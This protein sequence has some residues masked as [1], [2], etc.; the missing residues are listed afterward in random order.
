MDHPERAGSDRADRVDFDR[1][2]RLEFWGARPSVRCALQARNGRRTFPASTRSK[3]L[4]SRRRC[5]AQT[6]NQYTPTV[7]HLSKV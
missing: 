4:G 1:R 3:V 6:V 7:S 2:V 5:S